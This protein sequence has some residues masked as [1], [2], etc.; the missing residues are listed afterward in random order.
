M[1]N[2]HRKKIVLEKYAYKDNNHKHMKSDVK[3]H[4]VRSRF[5]DA[6]VR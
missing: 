6:I 5:D 1:F 4:W 3:V 2:K